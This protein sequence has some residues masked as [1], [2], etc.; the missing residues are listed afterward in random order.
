MTTLSDLDAVRALCNADLA[1]NRFGYE[2]CV[3]PNCSCAGRRQAM[4]SAVGSI[5]VQTMADALIA[6]LEGVKAAA[7]AGAAD[8]DDGVEQPEAGRKSSHG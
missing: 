6:A 2:T 7:R 5:M 4:I 8:K 3:A 1:E